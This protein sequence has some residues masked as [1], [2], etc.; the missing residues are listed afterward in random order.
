MAETTSDNPLLDTRSLPRFDAIRPE[1]VQPAISQLIE[2]QRLL[3]AQIEALA[4]PTFQTVVEPLE[5]MQHALGRVWSPVGH[6]NGVMNSESLRTAYNACLP[7]LSEYHTDLAQSE[8]LYQAYSQIAQQPGAALDP[9]QREVIEHALRDF[10]LAGVALDPA[11]KARF[12]AIMME[13]SRL[14]AKFEENV[15]DATNAWSHHV[16]DAGQVIGINQ[17]IIDQAVRR[18]QE[19]GLQG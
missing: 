14:S 7:L 16:T 8:R 1:H 18:A 11:R 5:E 10:R 9:V 4:N 13:L 3:V 19:K 15:L 2:R 6:L 12:K 17:G